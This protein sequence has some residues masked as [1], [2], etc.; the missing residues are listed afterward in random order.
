[1][2][3]VA[4]PD[5]L[6]KRVR[7]LTD[8]Y[9]QLKITSMLHS[10]PAQL[11]G[12]EEEEEEAKARS[13][14]PTSIVDIEDTLVDERPSSPGVMIKKS[15]A[16]VRRATR[17]GEASPAT[18]QEKA[19][20]PSPPSTKCP[21]IT[22]D[23]MGWLRFRKAQWRAQRVERRQARR[24]LPHGSASARVG[25]R[26]G[27]EDEQLAK[28]G[29]RHMNVESFLKN[30]T[31]A[32]THGHWQIIEVRETEIPGD[33]VIWAMTGH[34]SLQRLNLSIERVFYVASKDDEVSDMH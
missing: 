21:P 34:R 6:E 15:V 9:R 19:A 5:W 14:S 22:K 12:R 18:P 11:G 8:G 27:R 16:I 26:R 33:Y 2:P 10:K 25:A 4:H 1:M 20:P 13:V 3:R 23:F 24:S 31:M 7:D 30:A 17:P 29:K 32:V 28:T